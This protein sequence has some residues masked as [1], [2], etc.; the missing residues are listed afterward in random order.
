MTKISRFPLRDD[1]WERI[2]SL[3]IGTLADLKDKPKLASFVNDFF[4]PTERVMFAKRLATAVLVAKGH[5]Y[6]SIN[7]RGLRPTVFSTLRAV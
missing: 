4:S 2:F 1:V 3:F 5:S 6:D 7:C